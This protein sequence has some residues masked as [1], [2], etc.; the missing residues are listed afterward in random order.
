MKVYEVNVPIT[1]SM[2][3]YVSEELLRQIAERDKGEKID[4]PLSECDVERAMLFVGERA[5]RKIERSN[6]D[7]YEV[8]TDFR[9]DNFVEDF[10]QCKEESWWSHE[11]FDH[12]DAYLQI[13]PDERVA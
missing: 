11:D 10:Y 6:L 13:E 9:F 5:K 2:V 4:G 3:D 12:V 7:I 1:V 8:E